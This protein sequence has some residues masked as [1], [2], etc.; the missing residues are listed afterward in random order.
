MEK[1]PAEDLP[2]LTDVVELRPSSGATGVNP[3]VADAVPEDLGIHS[4]EELSALQ[5]ELVGRCLELTEELL[6]GAA[7]E[8][9]GVMFERV[10]DRL[11]SALPEIVALALREH[12]KPPRD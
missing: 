4:A 3:M 1:R 6:H 9:E 7:R 11:R 2:I 5:A 10:L 12:L 8:M